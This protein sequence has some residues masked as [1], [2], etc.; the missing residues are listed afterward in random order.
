MLNGKERTTSERTIRVNAVIRDE[1]GRVLLL[2]PAD[3]RGMSLPSFDVSGAPL[4]ASLRRGIR[5]ATGLDVSPVR[6][7]ALDVIP[8][9]RD[10]E[11]PERYCL[12]FDCGRVG[13]APRILT[14]RA[15]YD[16]YVWAPEEDIAE[17]AEPHRERRIR[18][19]LSA[20]E[21]GESLCLE[22]GRR[23]GQE[24]D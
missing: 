24:G 17:H 6:L 20:L 19:C 22:H 16:G 5:T 3:Q 11:T 7:L 14:H 4:H 9:D 8:E 15:K 18:E 12:V 13:N 23:A 1:T 2:D 10:K 21:S